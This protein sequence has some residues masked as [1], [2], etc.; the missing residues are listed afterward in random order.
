MR[1]AAGRRWVRPRGVGCRRRGLTTVLSGEPSVALELYRMQES[2]APLLGGFEHLHEASK[3]N[4]YQTGRAE[5]E[6]SAGRSAQA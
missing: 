6:A 5:P 4:E 3:K 2:E 1:A